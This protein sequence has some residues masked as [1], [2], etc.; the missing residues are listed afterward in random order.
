MRD[1]ITIGRSI[2]AELGEAHARGVLHRDVK[3]ANVIV[4]E[5]EP[6]REATVIDAPQIVSAYRDIAAAWVDA[7]RAQVDALNAVNLSLEEYRWVRSQAYAAIGVP[8]MELDVAKI[9]N[10]VMQGG[11]AK[12]PGQIGGSYE[13]SGPEANRD[14]VQR[15]KAQLEDNI[16]L[17]TFGL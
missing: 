1:T 12:A 17:A 15:V 4:D 6:L 11:E 7:K 8:F 13:P 9:V 14:R 2:L 3:P 10:E 5:G 16:A